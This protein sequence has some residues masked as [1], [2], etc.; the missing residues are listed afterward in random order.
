VPLRARYRTLVCLALCLAFCWASSAEAASRALTPNT[1]DGMPPP[2]P[3]PIGKAGNL[4]DYY[5]VDEGCQITIMGPGTFYFFVRADIPG[6]GVKPD[7]ILVTMDGI[8]GFEQQRWKYKLSKSKTSIYGDNHSGNPTGGK[9]TTL[10]MPPGL[11][12]LTVNATTTTGGETFG[13]FY[14]DGPPVPTPEELAAQEEARIQAVK[15]KRAWKFSGDFSLELIYDDNI[16]RFS[17]ETLVELESGTNPDKYGI[18][19]RDDFIYN[20]VIQVEGT[21]LFIKD[22]KSKIRF[23]YKIWQYAVSPKKNNWEYNIRLRQYT[24]KYSYFESTYTYAPDGYIKNL[25]DR[26]PFVSETVDRVY[27]GFTSTRNAFT[28]GY[29][30]R[31]KKWWTVKVFGGRTLRFYNRPFLEN[32]LWE[33][34]GK[35]ESDLKYKRFTCNIRYAFAN[36]TARGFD[37]VGETLMTSDN[38]GDGGYEKDT[39]R[40]KITYRPKRSPYRTDREGG[41]LK[42]LLQLGSLIDQGLNK[43][44]TSAIYVQY[45]YARQFYTSRRPLDV[46]PLHV[47]RVDASDQVQA[48]WNSKT[49]WNSIKLEAGIRYTVRTADSPAG[50]IGEDDPSDEKDY[51]GTRYWIA[52]DRPLW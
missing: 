39:Y 48:A 27:L 43:T 20:P 14:Y 18:E 28:L 50:N 47:G 40:L 37:E 49:I 31:V 9:K 32:D 35:L 26:P 33:W 41:W 36:D 13:V 25:R 17:D 42:P 45:Q 34:N 29:S 12:T 19:K 22:L 30:H 1:P 5:R 46:D 10:I 51:T 3:V 8:T 2:T 6:G 11:M 7:S 44:K 24:A 38:D 21:K 23:R 4:K 52:L 16:A 15:A